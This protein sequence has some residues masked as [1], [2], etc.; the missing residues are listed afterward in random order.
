MVC[1]NSGPVKNDK[2]KD[3]IELVQKNKR[4][5]FDYEILE[6]FEAGLVL[7]GPEVKSIRDGKV[8]IGESYARMKDGEV[9][10][11]NMDIAPYSHTPAALQEPK[12][13]R[14]LLLKRSELKK[15]A[16]N[17]REKG[18]TLV[19]LALYFKRGYAKL[20]IGL[21]KGK[22]KHDK[23]DAIRKR[24]AD[25]EMRRRMMRT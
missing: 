5:Y 10:V 23:R 14:K 16:G 7:Q 4:A 21:A 22:A 2:Q 20:E 19:P 8:S 15:L 13:P 6:K 11:I 1:Y 17:T 3:G 18:L 25:R 12:R 9:W 24:E